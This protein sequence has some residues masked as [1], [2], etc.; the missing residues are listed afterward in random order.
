[1][2]VSICLLTRTQNIA[3]D[4]GNRKVSVFGWICCKNGKRNPEKKPL[5]YWK[6]DVVLPI[7]RSMVFYIVFIGKTKNTQPKNGI[8][9]QKWCLWSFWSWYYI[10][11]MCRLFHRMCVESENDNI[12]ISFADNTKM[13]FLFQKHLHGMFQN[14]NIWFQCINYWLVFLILFWR[15]SRRKKYV[16]SYILHLIV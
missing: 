8:L 11:R 7:V 13:P 6:M 5:H 2:K 12:E 3:F 1:M 14:F 9:L 10:M 4:F 16:S 15:R